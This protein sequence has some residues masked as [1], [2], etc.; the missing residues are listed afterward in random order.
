MDEFNLLKIKARAR[1][2]SRRD[3][4]AGAVFNPFR[5]IS[6]GQPR[7]AATIDPV[8][9]RP[10]E[11]ISGSDSTAP[12]PIRPGCEGQLPI[13]S[14]VEEL[15]SRKP[16]KTGLFSHV[17]PNTPFTVRNQLQRIFLGAWINVFLLCV[18]A[19]LAL[20]IVL[21]D[22]VATFV[23]NIV[24][25][26]PLSFMVDFALEE[27]SMRLGNVLGG[28]LSASTSNFVQL[29]SSIVLL[30]SNQAV[31]VQTSLAGGI[32]ANVLLILGL[33]ILCGGSM[34]TYQY[35][36][37]EV[38]HTSANLLSLAATSLLIPTAS[39]LL[40]QTT[41]DGVAKQSRGA[42]FLLIAVYVSYLI[43]QFKTHPAVFEEEPQK[44]P[45]KSM[46]KRMVESAIRD[47]MAKAG[48][49]A[50]A[51]RQLNELLQIDDEENEVEPLL[52][53]RVAL[54]TFACSSALLATCVDFA[55]SSI[56][57]LSTGGGVSKTFIGLILLPIPNCEFT[58]ITYAT[59]DK[60]NLVMTFTIVKCLQT[61][62]FI[63]PLAVLLGWGLGVD[64]MTLVFNGFEV[65]SLF[66]AIL[67]LNFLM[68]EGKVTWI[69]GVLLLADWGLVAIAA[70]FTV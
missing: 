29:V 11:E 39:V 63:M 70:F 25:I 20:H 40:S 67:L 35:F 43:Y 1:A 33:S 61:A 55:V 30:K 58:T 8:D 32:L 27:I 57:A 45:R 37:L 16:K 21:G 17:M 10:R 60:M 4:G 62:L 14:S 46:G 47:G 5:H 12:E 31:L 19:G 3:E 36:S 49:D 23:I 22:H 42:S 53:F 9:A 56:N 64:D 13:T 66:A 24:A 28:L 50:V 68:I 15:E 26:V 34:R 65:V 38:A 41:Q 2:L 52:D 18:P 6:P 69:Q 59:D 7:R 51:E 54:T 48:A 44:V